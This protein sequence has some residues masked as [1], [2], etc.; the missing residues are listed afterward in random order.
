MLDKLLEAI[1]QYRTSTK[2]GA[3]G[4][5]VPPVAAALVLLPF[6]DHVEAFVKSACDSGDPMQFVVA[7]AVGWAVTW[8]SMFVSARKSKTP[9]DP[10]PL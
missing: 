2:S 4:L 10:G 3:T 5:V 8:V 7:A 6:Y 1:A 9:T